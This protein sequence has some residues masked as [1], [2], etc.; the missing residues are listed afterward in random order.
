MPMN[1]QKHTDTLAPRLMSVREWAQRLGVSEDTAWREVWSGRIP[2]VRVGRRRLIDD[3]DS[4]RYIA[5][6]K[7]T[8]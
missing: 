4:E 6:Q 3:R 7:E 1:L 8:V 5:Q 2:T